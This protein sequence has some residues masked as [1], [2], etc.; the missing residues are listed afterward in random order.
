[1]AGLAGGARFG[2]ARLGEAGHVG[3][4]TAWIK[5]KRR[6]YMV[7]EWKTKRINV[8]AQKVGEYFQEIEKREGEVKPQTIVEESATE[9]TLLHKYFEWDNTIAGNKYREVQ[10]Q[11]IIRNIVVVEQANNAPENTVSVRAFVNIESEE[12]RKYVSMATIHVEKLELQLLEQAR[13]EL[14]A[15]RNK[16]ASLKELTDLLA[17][18]DKIVI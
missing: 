4:G 9:G 15:F 6:I 11:Q 5:N 16:Y 1:M 12:K 3:A 14:Q 10:A 18:I 13:R 17:E 2:V 7:F 8:D